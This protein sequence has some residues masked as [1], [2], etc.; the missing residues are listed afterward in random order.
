MPGT[1]LSVDFHPVHIMHI[2]TEN[3]QNKKYLLWCLYLGDK[4][5]QFGWERKIDA[6]IT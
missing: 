3:S 1:S 4:G 5:L 6:K 2:K